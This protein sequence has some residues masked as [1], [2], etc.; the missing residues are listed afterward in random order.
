MGLVS[1]S[2]RSSYHTANRYY[3]NGHDLADWA[4]SSQIPPITSREM[5]SARSPI[6]NST[7]WSRAVQG[8]VGPL[9]REPPIDGR[10]GHAHQQRRFLLG[11]LQFTVAAQHRREHRQHQRQLLARRRMR[12]AQ[13]VTS[14]A[15]PA[16]H[17]ATPAASAP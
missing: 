17:T 10:R 14:A 16:G 8:H 1:R 13:Q 12:T 5:D 11:E 9:G 4:T 6:A 15:L 2:R 7:P 3:D